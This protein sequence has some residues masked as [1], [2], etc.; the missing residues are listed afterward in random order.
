TSDGSAARWPFPADRGPRLVPVS[1]RLMLSSFAMARAATLAGLGIALFPEFACEE[2][3]RR[4]RLVPVLDGCVVDVGKIWLL[5]PARRFLPARLRAF[6]D[7]VRERFDRTP[8][9]TGTTRLA[10]R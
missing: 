6:V 7:L 8:G 4:K 2:D 1:G 10:L 5:Y 3:L 9:T